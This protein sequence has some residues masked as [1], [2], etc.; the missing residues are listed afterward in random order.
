VLAAKR[1]RKEKEKTKEE[2]EE[3]PSET[4]KRGQRN[5]KK[6]RTEPDAAGITRD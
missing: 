1:S 6:K 4:R 5:G 2:E 3:F